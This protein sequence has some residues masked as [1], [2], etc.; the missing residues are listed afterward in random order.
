MDL[1]TNETDNSTSLIPSMPINLRININNDTSV[2][3]IQWDQPIKNSS[4]ITGY[5]LRNYNNILQSFN[6]SSNITTL[7]L[8]NNTPYSL[9]IA[10]IFPG[11]FITSDRTIFTYK[12]NSTSPIPNY[13]ITARINFNSN[14]DTVTIEWDKPIENSSYIKGYELRNN[15]NILKSFNSLPHTET[16]S[17]PKN[18][19]YFLTLLTLYEEKTELSWSFGYNPN[20]NSNSPIPN[21]PI[22]TN[23]NINDDTSVATI[24]WDKPKENSS[25]ITGYQLR[26][27][28]NILQSFNSSTNIATISLTNNTPYSLTLLTLYEGGS[29]LSASF[30]FTYKNKF[31]SEVPTSFVADDLKTIPEC[32]PGW[33]ECGGLPPNTTG[34]QENNYNPLKYIYIIF[35]LILTLFAIYLSFKCNEGFDFLSLLM[36]IFFPYIYIIYKYATSDTFCNILKNEVD[37][38]D[39]K[40]LN[41]SDE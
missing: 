3:T 23:L 20:P 41:K 10:A 13:N 32:K 26:N 14:N 16:I 36:A 39:D 2:A 25:Y 19:P 22:Y 35:H 15:N 8:T 18:T 30:V 33:D 37:D 9:T 6:S 34:T 40:E 31:N 29:V 1:F 11:G 4:Y 7:S 27:N 24:L 17:L 21:G 12:P 5:E 38:I 28:N